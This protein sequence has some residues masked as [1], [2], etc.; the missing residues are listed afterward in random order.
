MGN[1]KRTLWIA[2]VV[3]AFTLSAFAIDLVPTSASLLRKVE[4]KNEVW[5][6]LPQAVKSAVIS[7]YVAY[8]IEQFSL[9]DNS[10]YKLILKSGWNKLIVYYTA[11][12]EYLSQE[13]VKTAQMVA[14][15]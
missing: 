15:I 7:K 12:G 5:S 11:D 13:T 9:E 10:V 6:D 8:A 14:L 4:K 3:G 2:T 1:I